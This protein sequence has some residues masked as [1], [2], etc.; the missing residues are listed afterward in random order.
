MMEFRWDRVFW[1]D[2]PVDMRRT[3]NN[4]LF[5]IAKIAQS[6]PAVAQKS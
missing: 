1:Y 6:L 2:S 3:D 5:D 4:V